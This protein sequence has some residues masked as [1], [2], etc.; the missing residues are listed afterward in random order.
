MELL[1]EAQGIINVTGSVFE[2][3]V[4]RQSTLKAVV[5]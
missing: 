4:P 1:Q 3:P 5:R 2:A